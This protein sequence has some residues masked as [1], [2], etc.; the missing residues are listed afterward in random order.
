M[1]VMLR[2]ERKTGRPDPRLDKMPDIND[3]VGWIWKGFWK[4]HQTRGGGF[5]PQPLQYSDIKAFC[6][7]FNIED[8]Q[9]FTMYI[10]ELDL[11]YISWANKKQ[12]SENA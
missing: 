4:L 10:T 5:G 8:R 9:L 7:L 11:V 1:Y 12:G 3:E 6:D 2:V